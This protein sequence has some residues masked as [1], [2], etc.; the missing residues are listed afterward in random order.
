MRLPRVKPVRIR[1]RDYMAAVSRYRSHIMG[2]AILCILFFHG[3]VRIAEP[4]NY[5]LNLL[6]GV[7]IFFFCTGMGVYRSLSRNAD[8][9]AFYKRRFSRIY[10][11]YL[12]VVLLFFIPVLV[13]AVSAGETLSALRSLLGNLTMLGWINGLDAQFNWYPQVIC[14][15][16]LASPAFFAAVKSFNG[17]G[18]K[19]A[20]F[21]GFFVLT[22]VCFFNSGLLIAYSRLLYFLMGLIA[23]ELAERDAELRLNIPV[24]LV[25]FLAG[26]YLMYYGQRFPTEILWGYGLSWYPGLLII[27]G[28]MLLLCRVFALCEKGKPLGRLARLFE[29]MGRRSFEIFLIHLLVFGYIA[30]LGLPVQGNLMWL[31]VIVLCVPL[32]FGYGRLIDRVKK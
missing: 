7:D 6:W 24:L 14:M 9:L 22:Q 3:G 18:K 19:L 13:R 10:P 26:N 2:F 23:A 5:F 15:F 11:Y 1:I 25:F 28:A 17:S 12:P 20:V 27:P 30:D 16:Y 21:F 4:W 31:L 8:T 29:L 32:S